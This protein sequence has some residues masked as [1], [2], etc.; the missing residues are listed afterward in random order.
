MASK[1]A[2]SS[3][4]TSKSDLRSLVPRGTVLFVLCPMCGV[5][6]IYRGSGH[7]QHG[8]ASGT[9]LLQLRDATGGRGSGFPKLEEGSLQFALQHH[10]RFGRIVDEVAARCREIL[11]MVGGK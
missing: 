1:D 9:K 8:T 6:R 4:I 7:F 5:G 3:K 10:D 11:A 2:M